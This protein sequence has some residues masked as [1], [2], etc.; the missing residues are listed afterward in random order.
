MQSICQANGLPLE[1]G[2]TVYI[3]GTERS[4]GKERNPVA[5]AVSRI[6][7]LLAWEGPA[8]RPLADYFRLACLWGLDK[9]RFRAGQF[10][11]STL[12]P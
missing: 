9:G 5:A 1:G 8:V 3:R 7:Q 6:L 4:D 10:A 2:Y 12:L 11:A